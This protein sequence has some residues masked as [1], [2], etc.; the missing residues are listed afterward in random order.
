LLYWY[1][2][3]HTDASV[4]LRALR[5]RPSVVTWTASLYL[6]LKIASEEREEEEA[7]TDN[8][9]RLRFMLKKRAETLA[10]AER[11]CQEAQ[12]A[13]DEWLRSHVWCA[14]YLLYL[15]GPKAH[16]LTQKALAG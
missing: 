2:S 1:K 5:C 13:Y 9:Q 4:A 16:I 12:R 7:S 10:A 8:V 15:L 11:A 14:I 3:T 6:Y